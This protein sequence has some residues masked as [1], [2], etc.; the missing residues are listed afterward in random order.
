VE[1]GM[2]SDA[3]TVVVVPRWVSEHSN[4]WQIGSDLHHR[5]GT[6]VTPLEF[7]GGS[8]HY[9]QTPANIHLLDLA[10]IPGCRRRVAVA[11][12]S[13]W[14]VT[15]RAESRGRYMGAELFTFWQPSAAL[16]TAQAA[17]YAADLN[18]TKSTFG[19]TWTAS[20]VREVS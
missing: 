10:R 12:W 18:A 11:G 7:I 13:L 8:A 14:Q 16:A 2:T 4:W 5:D 15:I 19:Q 17:G 6:T 20:A 9:L 3:A 1:V